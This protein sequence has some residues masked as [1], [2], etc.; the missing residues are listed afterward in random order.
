MLHK[1]PVNNHLSIIVR[2]QTSDIRVALIKYDSESIKWS[3]H[4]FPIQEIRELLYHCTTP[5]KRRGTYEKGQH[6]TILDDI[7][8]ESE[9]P[10]REKAWIDPKSAAAVKVEELVSPHFQTY[11]LEAFHSLLNQFALN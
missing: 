6:Q 3:F 5:K 7:I 11:D 2:L 9:V 4:G 8:P 1:G 10:D